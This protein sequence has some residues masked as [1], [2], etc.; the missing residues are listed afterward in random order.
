MYITITAT[1]TLTCPVRA[2][3]HYVNLVPLAN[4]FGPLF[5]GGRFAPLS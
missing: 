2:L 5:S 1:N 4:Q 3:C